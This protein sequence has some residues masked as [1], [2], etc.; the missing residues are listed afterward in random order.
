MN[1]LY[2]QALAGGVAVVAALAALGP[3]ECVSNFSPS[4]VASCR[5]LIREV[6]YELRE[7]AAPLCDTL[8]AGDWILVAIVVANIACFVPALAKSRDWCI[9]QENMSHKT[10]FSYQFA[11]G[12][13]A[14]IAGNM[15]TLLAVGS[16]VSV[17]LNCN[18]LLLL[19]M[20]LACG[21]VGGV[22]AALLSNERTRTVG[23]SGSVSGVI[24]ALSVLR[25]NSAVYLLGDVT[26]ANPLMLLFGTLAADLSRGGISWQAHLGGGITG[27]VLAFL[28][29]LLKAV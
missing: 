1:L 11:H 5:G 10:L 2:T 29:K 16:E 27:A 6:P 26:A 18:Q 7:F 12:N 21:W 8:K 25:P 22:F 17:G 14:H 20:Y 19:A 23:A 13:I 28:L 15:L 4:L 3:S 9:S 24:V